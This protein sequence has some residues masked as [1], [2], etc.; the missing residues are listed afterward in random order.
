MALKAMA[1]N[2]VPIPVRY[3]ASLYNLLADKTNFIF[4]GI[5][6]EFKVTYGSGSLRVKLGTGGCLICGRHVF[7][8]STDEIYLTLSPN[9]SGYLV[10]RYDL[11]QA[12]GHEASFKAVSTLETGDLNGTGTKRDLLI[13]QYKTDDNG[14]TQYTD[15]RVYESLKTDAQI[16]T[17]GTS[18]AYDST[19]GYYTQLVSVVG[20]KS[21]EIP[22]ISVKRS[23]NLANMKKQDKEW[24]KV[25]DCETLNGQIKFI[26]SKA[27]TFN[28][29]L[30]ISS[31]IS[32]I[33]VDNVS[34]EQAGLDDLAKARNGQFNINGTE[35]IFTITNE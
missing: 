11:T 33:T 29:T 34:S 32:K 3:D 30:I 2:N 23:G 12:A 31:A 26:A 14:V 1:D 27:T 5:D 4:K 21:T 13:G 28:L 25:V 22:T 7:N 19:N 9:D 6:D 8:D 17:L 20:I 35:V 24:S 10:I 18:W 16:C 15:L